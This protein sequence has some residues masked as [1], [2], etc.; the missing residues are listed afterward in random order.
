ME[1]V[2]GELRPQIWGD[3][4]PAIGRV[5]GG[6]GYSSEKDPEYA[7]LYANCNPWA[8]WEHLAKSLYHHHQVA[9]V[10]EVRSYLPLRG[11]C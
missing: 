10:E 1:K 5:I 9:A 3:L 8:S 7:D 11:R 4:S 2:K 6:E